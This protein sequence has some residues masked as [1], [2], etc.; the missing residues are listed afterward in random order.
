MPRGK[1]S[2]PQRAEEKR[3]DSGPLI[4]DGRRNLRKLEDETEKRHKRKLDQWD[5]SVLSTAIESF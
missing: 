4:I 1:K 3:G 5:E 2:F